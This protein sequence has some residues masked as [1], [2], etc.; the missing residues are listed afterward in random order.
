LILILSGVVA[1]TFIKL[2][3]T[4]DKRQ[5]PE[6]SNSEREDSAKGQK[7]SSFY[8]ANLR[9]V[10]FLLQLLGLTDIPLLQITRN[11]ICAT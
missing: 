3:F 7:W 5:L 4:A 10:V 11:F 2:Y 1:R 9:Q 8:G 6:K